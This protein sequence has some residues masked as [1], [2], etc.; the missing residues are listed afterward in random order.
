MKKMRTRKWVYLG[1][2]FFAITTSYTLSSS[3]RDNASDYKED[4]RV[5]ELLKSITATDG[6][7]IQFPKTEKPEVTALKVEIPPGKETGWHMHPYPGYGYILQGTLTLETEDNKQ[8]KFE[9]GSAFVEVVNTSH[10]GKN[11]GKVPVILI[12]FFTGESG[13]PFTLR[14]D[15]K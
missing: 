3:A 14:A 12:V 2:L 6:R 7:P 15:K 5:T 9:P 1:S 13:K 8:F 4:V 11:L 10:N